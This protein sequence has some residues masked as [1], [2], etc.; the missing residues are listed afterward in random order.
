MTKVC[1]YH[2]LRFVIRHS[3]FVI[4][5]APSLP[6]RNPA[7]YVRLVSD[8]LIGALGAL[9]ATNPPT[10]LSNLV[11]TRTGIPIPIVDAND[12]VEKEYIRLMEMDDEAQDE[13]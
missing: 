12:P 9:L 11:H 1:E 4:E 5:R 2:S 8:L 3:S 10:A 6:D 13:V 7:C